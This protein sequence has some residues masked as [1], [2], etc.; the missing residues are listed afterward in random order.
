MLISSTGVAVSERQE[1]GQPG[2]IGVTD[3]ERGEV[4]L[5][6]RG[7]SRMKRL[8]QVGLPEP[9]EQK[10]RVEWTE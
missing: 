3:P 8:E 9:A 7:Q 6:V 2:V 10:L 4:A 1:F 5:A